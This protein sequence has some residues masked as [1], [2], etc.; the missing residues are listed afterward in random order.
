MSKTEKISY[1]P[2]T[3]KAIPPSASGEL[4]EFVHRK[5]D[6]C[7]KDCEVTAPNYA[8]KL[9]DNFHCNFCLR[10]GLH[11]RGNRDVLILSFRAILGHFYHHHYLGHAPERMWLSEIEDYAESHRH[12]GETNPLFL[13]DPETLLWFV[14][15]SRVGTSKKKLPLENILQTVVS[16]LATFNL[17]SG[18]ASMSQLFQSYKEAIESF[19]HKRSRPEGRRMLIP[20]LGGSDKEKMR[21]FIEF[22]KK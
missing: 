21:G 11:T 4:S 18:P 22:S 10:H 20:T 16:I 12:A 19:Y 8:Q 3:I 7:E 17:W 13:Y 15:F 1:R 2:V 9:S 6:F 14:N 5:C